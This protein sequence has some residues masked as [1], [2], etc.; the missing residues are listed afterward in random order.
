MYIDPRLDVVTVVVT[1]P[2]LFTKLSLFTK[3]NLDKEFNM[4]KGDG[5]YSLNRIFHH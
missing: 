2:L 1:R 3:S 4:K 5:V